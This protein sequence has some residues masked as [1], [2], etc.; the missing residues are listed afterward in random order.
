MG[1]NLLC[2]ADWEV[3]WMGFTRSA[4]NYLILLCLA[5]RCGHIKAYL[6]S[7]VHVGHLIM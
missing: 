4:K 5:G 1:N 3:N 2:F 7:Q 6:D